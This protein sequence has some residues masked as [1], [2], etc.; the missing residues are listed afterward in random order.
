V[1]GDKVNGDRVALP[2]QPSDSEKAPKI[3][4]GF[5]NSEQISDVVMETESAPKEA[6]SEQEAP[7]EAPIGPG[8]VKTS[9]SPDSIK[10]EE[11]DKIDDS[12]QPTPEKS[13][14]SEQVEKEY[15]MDQILSPRVCVRL[16]FGVGFFHVSAVKSKENP[17]SYSD[18]MLA[19]RWKKMIEA[20]S[21]VGTILDV[22]GMESVARAS[23]VDRDDTNGSSMDIDDASGEN[24]N[25][26]EADEAMVD[27]VGPSDAT[28]SAEE[29]PSHK[30]FLPF[31]ANLLPTSAGRG[32]LLA[33]A[34]IISLETLI[35]DEMFHSGGV[36]G[37]VSLPTFHYF[38]SRTLLIFSN[39]TIT[40]EYIS[41]I[42]QGFP[43][44]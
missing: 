20:A 42:I 30:R 29:V 6:A 9:E 40:F 37:L 15:H 7:K 27:T 8:E 33:E 2:G 18:A 44:L 35:S 23:L 38:C 13:T 1:N 22:G 14:S 43:N 31:G 5:G 36:L 24:E 32:G 28:D 10:L 12:T 34:P 16:Q 26:D 41:M 25:G 11:G 4:H 21:M 17:S 19:S 39:E 3:G